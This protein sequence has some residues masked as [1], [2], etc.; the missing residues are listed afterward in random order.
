M[1]NP[2]ILVQH[3]LTSFSSFHRRARPLSNVLLQTKL[4][5]THQPD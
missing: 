3:H 5:F 1:K 4:G 2:S